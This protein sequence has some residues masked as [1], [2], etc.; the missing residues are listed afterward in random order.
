MWEGGGLTGQLLRVMTFLEA[1]RLSE[2]A[3]KEAVGG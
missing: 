2:R 3:V 1:C